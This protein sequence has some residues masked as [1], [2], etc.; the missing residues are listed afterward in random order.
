MLS[1]TQ[2]LKHLLLADCRVVPG[3]V[4]GKTLLR[5]LDLSGCS[6][7]GGAAG[8]VVQLM[9]HLQPLQQLTYLKLQDSLRA[10]RSGGK[11]E[12]EDAGCRWGLLGCRSRGP[13]CSSLLSPDSKQ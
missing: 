2:H 9:S 3:V 7:S 1:G 8:G 12:V 6:T 4:A 11:S 10:E 13:S 5:H